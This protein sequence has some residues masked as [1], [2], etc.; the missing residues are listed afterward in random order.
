MPRETMS[1]LKA[2]RDE[3]RDELQRERERFLKLE[4]LVDT[5]HTLLRRA[6]GDA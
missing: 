3:L 1:D 6:R 4:A 5:I 2:E